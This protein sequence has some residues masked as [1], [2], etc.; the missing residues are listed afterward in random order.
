MSYQHWAQALHKQAGCY[1]SLWYE[2]D[3]GFYHRRHGRFHHRRNPAHIDRCRRLIEQR[4]AASENVW[5]VPTPPCVQHFE[6][7]GNYGLAL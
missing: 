4:N 7:T 3:D 5:L 1:V 2:G 6:S